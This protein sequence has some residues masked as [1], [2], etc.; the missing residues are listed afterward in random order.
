MA[1]ELAKALVSTTENTEDT[2]KTAV[3]IV[4]CSVFSVFSVVHPHAAPRQPGDEFKVRI[5]R[6]EY[7]LVHYNSVFD[8]HARRP[9][10]AVGMLTYLKLSGTRVGL[11]INFNVRRLVD[12]LTRFRDKPKT[13]GSGATSR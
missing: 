13:A 11:L 1:W 10:H 6:G 7:P 5:R 3:C 2:E 9:G 4:F 12:G 8:Q